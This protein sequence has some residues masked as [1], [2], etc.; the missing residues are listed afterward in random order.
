MPFEST[1][2]SAKLGGTGPESDVI[3]AGAGP[4]GLLLALLLARKG[5]RSKVFEKGAELDTSP[6]AALH[7]PL[8]PEVFKDAGIYDIV[9][10]RGSHL[11][12]P[13]WRKRII[14]DGNG[15]KALGP[16]I[17]ELETFKRGDDG[18]FEEGKVAIIFV[19]GALVQV[20]LEEATKTNLVEVHFS[21][22][23]MGLEQDQHRV[24]SRKAPGLL[25][26]IVPRKPGLWRFAMAVPDETL[27]NEEVGD[28]KYVHEL[29]LKY[30]YGPRPAECN[31]V[32][33]RANRLTAP[34]LGKV[35]LAG[36]AAHVN[37]PVGGLGLCTGLLDV[38]LLSQALD[39]IINHDYHDP[40]DL[41]AE[42]SA[43]RQFVFQTFV[44]PISS[45]NKIRLHESD[46]DDAAGEDWFFRIL[47]RNIPQEIEKA[48]T[49]LQQVWRTDIRS[50]IK[51]PM[52]QKL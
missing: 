38:D 20:L 51:D 27:T 24:S 40:Q 26:E 43:A 32:R 36:D 35:L 1:I 44:S 31:L 50:I 47:R 15:G 48:V 14:D 49:P 7:Y 9:F 18:F 2:E 19:Q 10:Q 6:R 12:G 21:T 11:G 42:Y 46:P 30:L 16:V 13:L 29:L 5:I 52:K 37:N 41:L 23:I 28:P 17:A 39:L 25:R 33:R 34:A 4:V 3:I 45:A 8:V 22:P